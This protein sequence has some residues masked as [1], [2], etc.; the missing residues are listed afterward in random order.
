MVKRHS[1]TFITDPSCSVG[2]K[3]PSPQAIKR[4][5]KIEKQIKAL[6]VKLNKILGLPVES[7]Q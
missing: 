1:S 6:K 2:I 5:A 7:A 3:A 4:A